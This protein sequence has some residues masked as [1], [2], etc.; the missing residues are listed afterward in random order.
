MESFFLA[1]T[2]KYLYL[3]FD[4]DNF[5][6]NNGGVATVI[7]TPNGECVIDSGGYIFNTEAHPVDPSAL[8]CCHDIP[9]QQLLADY[10]QTKFLGDM[11]IL[12]VAEPEELD[13]ESPDG[14]N[15]DS[16]IIRISNVTTF[17]FDKL[18]NSEQ[19]KKDLLKLLQE[20][21]LRNERDMKDDSTEID[22][23]DSG[24]LIDPLDNVSIN[25]EGSVVEEFPND[26]EQISVVQTSEFEKLD[27]EEST[28]SRN[29]TK[30]ATT[31]IRQSPVQRVYGKGEATELPIGDTT[32]G[33]SKENVRDSSQFTVGKI[34]PPPANTSS[35]QFSVYEQRVPFDA[36]RFLERVRTMH[37]D[38][39]ITRNYELLMCKTQPYTQRLAVMGEILIT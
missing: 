1:E 15:N 37:D 23:I 11:V 20:L 12:S 22:D 18:L 24:D 25:T 6:N 21:K 28:V 5:L 27:I 3:L 38:K 17:N 30:S 34:I 13:D 19:D 16:D 36:Q 39:N 8:R 32:F 7:N 35:P 2:T 29:T 33:E 10:N 9:R 4:P 26:S 14:N 31:E